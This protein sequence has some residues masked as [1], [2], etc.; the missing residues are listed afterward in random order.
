MIDSYDPAFVSL[1]WSPITNTTL[2][3]DYQRFELEEVD[4]DDFD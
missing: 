2:G 4:G 1:M 3:I